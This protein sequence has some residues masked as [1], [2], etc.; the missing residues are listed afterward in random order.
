MFEE[1]TVEEGQNHGLTN[2]SANLGKSLFDE[3]T[4]P[5]NE[6]ESYIAAVDIIEDLGNP[7][8]IIIRNDEDG[9][10]IAMVYHDVEGE[11]VF[12]PLTGFSLES[13]SQGHDMLMSLLTFCGTED[14]EKVL[15]DEELGLGVFHLDLESGDLVQT[16]ELSGESLF[17]IFEEDEEDVEEDHDDLV[18]LGILDSDEAVETEVDRLESGQDWM[19]TSEGDEEDDDFCHQPGDV[20]TIVSM[21]DD[22]VLV[23]FGEYDNA[24]ETYEME[25]DEF[26]RRFALID[27]EEVDEDDLEAEAFIK[28]IRGGK[29]V[30]KKKRIGRPRRMSPKQK[31]A[32]KKARKKAHSSSARK[33]RKKSSLVRKRKGMESWDG[34]MKDTVEAL[35]KTDS[36]DDLRDV[37]EA[38]MVK[39]VRGGKV[40]RIKKKLRRRRR[41]SSKQKAALKKAQRASR[42]PGAKRKRAKSIKIRKRKGL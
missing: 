6:V 26:V 10:E 9:A 29:V 23:Q 27:G 17:A 4:L 35:L 20:A 12:A 2:I 30:K 7:D 40:V 5:E 37:V 14:I 18:E 24:E 8:E 21:E 42:K 22:S 39:V 3:V 38:R 28:V 34:S 41:M 31:A 13:G 1:G 33:K 19:A 11:K 36:I 32:L 16:A 15:S 25:K